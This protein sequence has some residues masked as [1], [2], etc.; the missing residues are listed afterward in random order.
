MSWLG[1]MSQ[2]SMPCSTAQ[3]STSLLISFVPLSGQ[4][5]TGLPRMEAR[6]AV[7][8]SHAGRGGEPGVAVKP[9]AVEEAHHGEQPEP[10]LPS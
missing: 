9:L 1:A 10:Q 2:H 3:R 6:M 4:I 8:V 7:C 5:V